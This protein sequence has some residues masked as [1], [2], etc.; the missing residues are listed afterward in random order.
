MFDTDLLFFFG[1]ILALTAV[2]VLACYLLV[3]GAGKAFD[4]KN[5]VGHLM[6]WPGGLLLGAFIGFMM[7]QYDTTMPT[8]ILIGGI[9]SAIALAGAYLMMRVKN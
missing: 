5:P 6:F 1:V 4:E 2:G 3:S 8:I 7:M 9:V